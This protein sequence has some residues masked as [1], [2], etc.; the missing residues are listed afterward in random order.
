MGKGKLGGRYERVSSGRLRHPDED[1][2]GVV[3]HGIPNEAGQKREFH[4]SASRQY[5]FSDME[6]GTHTI[7]A[8]TFTD[9]LRI[10]EAMGFTRADYKKR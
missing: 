5:T 1:A 2:A 4:G 3:H 8:E 10:A 9:A 6:H 7:A